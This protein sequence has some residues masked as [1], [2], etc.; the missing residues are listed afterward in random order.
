MVLTISLI[1]CFSFMKY[2]TCSEINLQSLHSIFPNPFLYKKDYFSD[3]YVPPIPGIS[4][5]AQPYVSLTQIFAQNK[6][7]EQ[8]SSHGRPVGLSKSEMLKQENEI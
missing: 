5:W 2:P 1:V 3:F 4:A 6:C 8:M 7:W